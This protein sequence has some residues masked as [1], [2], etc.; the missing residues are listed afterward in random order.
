MIDAMNAAD[1][2]VVAV[3]VLSMLLSLLRGFTREAISLASW[4]LALV[5]ARVLSPALSVVFVTWIDDQAFRDWLAF[6][7]L[8]IA[9]LVTGMLVAHMMG[10]AVRN[11]ALNA[12]D[13]LLGL[14]FGFVRGVLI[15]VVAIAFGARWW[16]G[17]GWWTESQ[18]IPRL[19]LLE[20]WTREMTQM[21]IVWISG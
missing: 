19:A 20:G 6:V 11:S 13:R 2:V 12:G 17:E 18:I 16:S 8:F 3:V 14:G 9:I 7:T 5:G 4:V 15:V 10:E 1:W 21:L